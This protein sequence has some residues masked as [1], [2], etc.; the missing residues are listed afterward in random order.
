MKPFQ[1]SRQLAC[2]AIILTV[3]NCK[4]TN[5]NTY[6]IW[7][8][9]N[10]SLTKICCSKKVLI[11]RIVKSRNTQSN[12]QINAEF[13]YDIKS[14]KYVFISGSRNEINLSDTDIQIQDILSNLN[15]HSDTDTEFTEITKTDRTKLINGK[16]AIGFDFKR[17]IRKNSINSYI[18]SSYGTRWIEPNLKI[19]LL[20]EERY[21]LPIFSI[22]RLIFENANT[23]VSFEYDH[24]G[25]LISSGIILSITLKFA[26][27][28][29]TSLRTETKHFF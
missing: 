15:S 8:A 6:E 17:K 25:K 19:C 11:D 27:L 4:P 20:I 5:N 7:E 12:E 3:H 14:K 22:Y 26:T 28:V 21:S 29:D 16:I 24:A 13:S 2:F 9:A 23:S 1:F 10:H 18:S